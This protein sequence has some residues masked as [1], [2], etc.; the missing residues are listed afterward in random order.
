MHDL[1]IDLF[2]EKISISE[3]SKEQN[4]MIKKIEELKDFILL[5]K[6]YYKGTK[7]KYYKES[8]DKSTK[9]NNSYSTKKCFKKCINAV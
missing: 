9:K 8:R 6:K 4:E 3:A 7:T 2:N 5:E 1:F